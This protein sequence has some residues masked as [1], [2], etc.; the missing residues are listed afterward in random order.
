LAHNQEGTIPIITMLLDMKNEVYVRIEI[1]EDG[2]KTKPC[3]VI[4]HIS[5]K[6]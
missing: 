5:I 3:G 1:K 4:I 6:D 2:L